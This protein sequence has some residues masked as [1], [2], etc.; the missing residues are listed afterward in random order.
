MDIRQL[1]KN[2]DAYGRKDPL[3]AIVSWADKKDNK[4]DLEEFLQLGVQEVDALLD[5]IAT[6]NRPLQRGHALDFGCG[7]GRLTQALAAHFDRVAGVDIAPSMIE[8]ARRINRFGEKCQYHLNERSDLRLFPD[9]QF[10]FIYTNITLQHMEPRYSKGYLLEFLRI[11]K[12]GGLLV[13]QLPGERIAP[14]PAPE[15]EK[16]GGLRRLYQSLPAPLCNFLQT[17]RTLRLREP[18]MEMYGIPRDEVTRFLTDHGGHL[19]DVTENK[20]GGPSWTSFRYCI[21]R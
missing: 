17:I 6:L 19:L 8:Q 14:R 16:A 9:R 15:P 18:R 12:P 1:Q 20:S 3:F 2:W 10:D 4:W 13:F 11:L 7:V 21:T 5:Y